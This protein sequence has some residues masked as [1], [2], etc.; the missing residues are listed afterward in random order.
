MP[1][2]TR[3]QRGHA[4]ALNADSPLPRKLRTLLIAID[5]YTDSHTYIS[6]LS[7]FGDVQTLLESLL[8]AGLIEVGRGHGPGNGPGNATAAAR[9]PPPGVPAPPVLTQRASIP[10]QDTLPPDLTPTAPPLRLPAPSW[11]D[12]IAQWERT[13]VPGA[14]GAAQPGPGAARQTS[15]LP[16]F[17]PSLSPT[18]APGGQRPSG[19]GVDDGRAENRANNRGDFRAPTAA[20]Y[21]GGLPD[22]RGSGLLNHTSGY[23]LKQAVSL[24]SDFVSTHLPMQAIEIVLELER[25]SSVEQLIASLSGYEA[26]IGSQGEAARRHLTELRLVLSSHA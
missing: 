10:P 26:L 9:T 22:R 16:G 24:M 8:N 17:S 14:R 25:L 12:S 1:I 5:G 2:Y 11:Q 6:S 21:G 3:T 15:V 13:A 4:A 23:Q 7:A 19:F 18:W 20:A